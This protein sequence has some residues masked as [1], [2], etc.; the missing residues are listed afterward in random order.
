MTFTLASRGSTSTMPAESSDPTSI[1]S[2]GGCLLAF[3]AAGGAC[4]AAVWAE[5]RVVARRRESMVRGQ[6]ERLMPIIAEVVA[7]SACAY[8]DFGILAATRGPGGFTGVRITLA[9]G[10]GLALALGR[11]LLG[12]TN[13][14]AIA[15]AVPPAARDGRLLAVLIES[16]RSEL[17]LQAFDSARQA[18]MPGRLVELEDLDP[19][20]PPGPLLL[21]G[22]GAERALA[23]LS[24][25]GRDA[26]LAPGS[27]D[28][29][30]ATVAALVAGR[31]P[32]A[33]GSI[34][35][36]YLRAPDVTAPP[37]AG[38]LPPAS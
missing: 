32:S 13:F 21:A 18:L 14:E 5:G 12:V 33:P 19:A 28:C 9:T 29:D 36:L 34:A 15:A 4:S 1:A 8:Q 31:A 30:A 26:V 20:L 24:A 23:A 25:C 16:K 22:D 38:R 2:L 7:Q 35:P 3:D 6:A 37:G 17:Y 27:Q 11:P 10:R